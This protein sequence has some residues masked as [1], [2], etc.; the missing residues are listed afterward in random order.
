MYE[1]FA[2]E[3]KWTI[4]QIQCLSRMQIHLLLERMIDRKMR[5]N[6]IDPDDPDKGATPP[7]PPPEQRIVM[8][9]AAA[10]KLFG[11]A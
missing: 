7:E 2:G 5:E 1:Q 9:R 4:P 3:Y 10:K 6:G 8:D 11:K